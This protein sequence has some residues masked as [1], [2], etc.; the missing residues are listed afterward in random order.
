M[1][2]VKYNT[3]MANAQNAQ[4]TDKKKKDFIENLIALCRACHIKAETD[5]QFNN[6]LR[7]LN[8]YKHNHSY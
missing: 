5:K 8:K 1:W 7:E 4:K 6:Q 2:V 3:T